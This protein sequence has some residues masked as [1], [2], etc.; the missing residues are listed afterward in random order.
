MK[1]P[2]ELHGIVDAFAHPLVFATVS[3]AHLYGFPSP[4]SD[5]D[6]RGCHVLPVSHLVGLRD[7]EETE[8]RLGPDAGLD[9][10]LVSHDLR[11]FARLLLRRNG[12]VLEQ[13]LSPLIVR[14]S[15]VHDELKALVPALLT[16]HH[17]HHY[18]GFANNQWRM[19]ER[20]P[21]VKTLLYVYRVLFT[22]IH[23]MRSA[24]VEASLPRLLDEASVAGAGADEGRVR[25]LLARKLEGAEKQ[26]LPAAAVDQ[27]RPAYERLCARL[28]RERDASALPDAPSAFAALDELVVRARLGS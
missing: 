14:T 6:L 17:A 2:A 9:L 11:K 22:G 25:E 21:R 10:D 4:D 7:P 18:L 1:L 28:E 15:P 5:Y 23:L 8:E 26:P 13:L 3:G 24:E 20:A 19:F 12:Y 16:R 27:H